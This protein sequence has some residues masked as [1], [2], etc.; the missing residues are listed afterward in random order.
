MCKNERRKEEKNER[1]KGVLFFAF[2]SLLLFFHCATGEAGRVCVI[3]TGLGGLP[4]YE[5]N[6]VS[7]GSA[8]EGIFR[9]QLKEKVHKLD[10]RT[11]KRTEI[12]QLFNQ[13]SASPSQEEVWLFLIGHGNYDGSHYKFNIS[14]P[15]LTDE[16]LRTFLDGL[17]ERRAYLIA[18]T[19][20][21]GILIPRLSKENRVVV[22]ATR[23]QSER[24]PPLFLSFF[25]E[26]T[27]SARADTDK[28]GK[29]SLLEAFLFTQKE[30]ASWFQQKKRLQTEHALLDDN[31]D[32]RGTAQPNQTNGE[33][34]LASMAYL[35]APTEQAYRSL[36]A[37]QLAREKVSLERKIEDLKYQKKD[38]TESDYYQELQKLLV[39]LA[40]LSERI[41]ELEGDK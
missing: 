5:K 36:E 20:A 26:G 18:A 39:K 29:V 12:L 8:I 13:V 16:D 31:G 6:F 33:G 2:W 28:N 25:I 4:E 23:N 40:T 10:G 15:D 1:E 22:S 30:V 7:W 21:S 34:S 35:S 17:K 41:R 38:L 9:D 11:Q 27:T 32:G 14:G 24:Q 37:Q 3:V 19:G